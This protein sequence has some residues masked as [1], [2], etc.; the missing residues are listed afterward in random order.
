LSIHGSL[1]IRQII[2]NHSAVVVA[3]VAF[4]TS[5]VKSATIVAMAERPASTKG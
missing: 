4:Q 2:S 3:I 5:A 1:R